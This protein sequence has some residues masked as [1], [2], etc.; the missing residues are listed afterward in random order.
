MQLFGKYKQLVLFI[1]LIHA[2]Y[3]GMALYFQGIYTVDSIG[4]LFQADNI[5]HHHSLYSEDFSKPILPDYFS[6][7]PPLY[8]LFI[9]F[10]KSIF[11]SNYFVLF[12]QNLVSISLFFW[13]I[14]F[15]DEL[16]IKKK[17]TQL[18]IPLYLIFYPAQFVY[19]NTIM[20]EILFQ[21]LL[22]CAF[23]YSYRIMLNTTFKN[24][25]LMCLFFA[26]AMITKPVSLLIGLSV[27][28]FLLLKKRLN[29]F[30]LLVPILLLPA[31][32]LVVSFINKDATGYFHFTSVKSIFLVKYMVKYTAV[33]AYNEEYADNLVSRIMNEADKKTS[34]EMRLKYMDEMGYKF[35]NEHKTDFVKL[36][37]KGCIAFMIDPGRYDIYKFYEIKNGTIEGYHTFHTKGANAFVEFIK[38]A[39]LFVV[40]VLAFNLLWN[41]V[42]LT[43][44]I[45]IFFSKKIP[46]ILKI[47]IGIFIFYI[48]LSTGVLGL[49]RYRVPIF[50]QLLIAFL[51]FVQHSNFLNK[52]ISK[53]KIA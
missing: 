20:S 18:F 51:L 38:T 21:F 16:K 11:C 29:T 35:I 4:Y 17:H 9:L 7:R 48:M 13:I 32:F 12:I 30:K 10:C 2:V 5:I 36:F 31:T 39:P 19:V 47:L 43:F 1:I 53:S 34:Y 26:L 28:L 49:S 6:F 37:A 44:F 52:I 41:V 15:C 22:F 25:I 42:V 27:I 50:P 23:Y 33:S 46:A 8:S 14:K 45:F 24:S 3:F 40:I